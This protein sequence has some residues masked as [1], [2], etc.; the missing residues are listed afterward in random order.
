MS[1]RSS[2][3]YTDLTTS[4]EGTGT[5]ADGAS[6]PN[7]NDDKHRFEIDPSVARSVRLHNYFVGGDGNFSSDR[8]AARHV[9]EEIPG[10]LETAHTDVLA[11]GAFVVRAVRYLAEDAGLRQFL[12]IGTTVP[13]ENEVHEVAQA[14]APDARVVYVGHDPVVLAHAHELRATK[15]PQGAVAYVHGTVYDPQRILDDAAVTLDLTEPVAIVLVT[16]LNFIPDERDPQGIV[17][18]LLQGVPSGSHLVVVH[19]ASDIPAEGAA[20]AFK[21]L[22]ETLREGFVVRSQAEIS[23]F[24]AGLELVSPGLV[25]LDLWR[26]PAGD[27]A[28]QQERLVPAYA[29]VARKP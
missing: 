25:P 28:P 6:G 7:D 13:A 15:S 10:G 14:V 18:H 11:L 4:G 20:E 27:P 24:F 22:N 21:R 2:D 23:R 9:T 19:V 17:A 1:R 29:A 8:D 16:T 12:H 3:S 5:V 26:R